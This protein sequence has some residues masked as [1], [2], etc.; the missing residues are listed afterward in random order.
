MKKIISV[1]LAIVM[2][3]TLAMPA[4]AASETTTQVPV[5]TS[6]TLDSAFVDGNSLIV[7]VL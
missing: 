5:R 7:F 2:L 4:F 6:T 3:F 1:I